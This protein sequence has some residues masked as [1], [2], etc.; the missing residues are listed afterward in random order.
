MPLRG[1]HYFTQYYREYEATHHL[2]LYGKQLLTLPTPRYYVFYIGKTKRPEREELRLTDSF[3]K[4]G[5]ASLEV[6]ATVLNINYDQNREILQKCK[7]LRDYSYLVY[8]IRENYQV[9]HNLDDAIN[10]AIDRCIKEDVL[11]EFLTSQRAEVSEMFA[12]NMTLEEELELKDLNAQREV[13]QAKQ[14]TVAAKTESAKLA[15][16]LDTMINVLRTNGI[17]K[18]E[19]QDFDLDN[20]GDIQEL[21]EKYTK[22]SD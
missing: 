14:E 7:V 2:D 15:K 8:R 10:K 21:I 6:T 5:E 22:K 12:M 16:A 11:R 3:A 17:M 13:E 18:L 19:D 1:L 9:K 4:K 20:L